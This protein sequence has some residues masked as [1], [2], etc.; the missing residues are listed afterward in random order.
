MIGISSVELDTPALLV[1]LDILEKNL[2]SMQ[3]KAN[4]AGV[5][6]RPHIKTHR[7]PAIARLQ[8][9]MGARGITAAKL[10]E[11]EVMAE[12]GLDDIFIANEIVGPLKLERLKILKRNLVSLA[13][14]VDHPEQV[15][16]LSGVFSAE[17]T[18]LDVMIDVETGSP[19]TGVLS[20]GQ[21]LELARC[22]CGAPGLRLRGIFTH[23]GHSYGAASVE[24]VRALSRES[25]E[26]MIETAS[27]LRSAGINVEEVSI[28]STPSLL[29]GGIEFGVTEI[30]PGNYAFLDANMA[31]FL[32]TYSRCA[33]TVLA[34]VI[35][36]PTPER[37]VLDVG[38]KTLNEGVQKGGIT[39][40]EGHGRLKEQ[41]DIFLD[42]IYEEHASFDIPE[43]SDLL[44]GIGQKLEII[45]NH[46]CQTTNFYEVIHGIRNGGVETTWPVSCRG[47]SR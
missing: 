40:A 32:G 39:R 29:L 11:A 14:G 10:G 45:P 35:S 7:T 44:F 16:A 1:D 9:T 27:L 22:V 34:T 18:P 31:Q 8:V 21:A 25:Q 36:R 20:G 15:V 33:Q 12:A 28:G 47:K 26:K 17:P 19:R 13:V 30:R 24:A 6:M 3:E 2:R 38:T 4:L 42:R 46:A 43:D 23:D 37:V 5:K 41:P